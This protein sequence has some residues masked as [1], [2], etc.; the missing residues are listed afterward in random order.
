MHERKDWGNEK[1][2]ETQIESKG[3]DRK[4]VVELRWLNQLGLLNENKL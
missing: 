3:S 2:R 1:T 4:V